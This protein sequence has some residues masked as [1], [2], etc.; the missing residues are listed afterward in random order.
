MVI[1]EQRHGHHCLLCRGSDSGL[2][3]QMGYRV[4]ARDSSP[5]FQVKVC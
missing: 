1:D 2:S 3:Y 5:L 4:G